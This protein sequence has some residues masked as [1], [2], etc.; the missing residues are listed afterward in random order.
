VVV[1]LVQLVDRIASHV[2]EVEASAGQQ[3]RVDSVF[4]C[5]LPAAAAAALRRCVIN[6]AAAAVVI[7]ARQASVGAAW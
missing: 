6:A 2:F 1:Q 7:A 4:L 5:W 3:S